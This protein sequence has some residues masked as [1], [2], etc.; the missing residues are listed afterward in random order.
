[1]SYINEELQ[2]LDSLRNSSKVSKSD[3]A[4]LDKFRAYTVSV[5]QE[6]KLHEKKENL[7]GVLFNV[8]EL[9]DEKI[10]ELELR[11][12]TEFDD[13][14]VEKINL[15]IQ[16]LNVLK[17]KIRL[18]NKVRLDEL[19]QKADSTKEGEKVIVDVL[20]TL[21]RNSNE[22]VTP[23]LVNQGSVDALFRRI[24]TNINIGETMDSMDS[25]DDE[26]EEIAR[27]LH[28]ENRLCKIL[29]LSIE[30]FNVVERY[31]DRIREQLM[32]E[33]EIAD[34][35]EKR[36]VVE[37]SLSKLER[38]RWKFNST[39]KKIRTLSRRL[40]SMN[41]VLGQK[42]QL[43]D[44][45]MEHVDNTRNTLKRIGLGELADSIKF[46]NLSFNPEKD[47]I[48]CSELDSYKK[49]I[50]VVGQSKVH[51]VALVV[52]QQT[53]R[54]YINEE[55]SSEMLRAIREA[56][57]ASISEIRGKIEVN[58]SKKYKIE[59]DL[60]DRLMPFLHRVTVVKGQLA[61]SNTELPKVSRTSFIALLALKTLIDLRRDIAIEELPEDLLIEA[62]IED[63]EKWF[64]EEYIDSVLTKADQGI[65]DI[66]NDKKYS[67]N[68]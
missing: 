58:R 48:E 67:I 22:L 41:D 31:V 46:L 7:E 2:I 9:I 10:Q 5:V 3:K 16:E 52:L 40:A 66:E 63:L 28:D 68:N 11:A 36:A 25:L 13:F 35:K 18:E 26:E 43:L 21:S 51:D 44:I 65:K 59:S 23:E 12:Q 54:N 15:K 57:L 33:N 8:F 55:S 64:K 62:E 27:E 53:N 17:R 29:G 47:L 4:F 45:S 42:S 56:V 60:V 1:M 50:T 37:K 32:Y 38:R 14:L 6:K 34:L 39:K 61:V 20:G 24:Y 19:I 49:G 30:H